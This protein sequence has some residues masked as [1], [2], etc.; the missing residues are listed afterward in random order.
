MQVAGSLNGQDRERIDAVCARCDPACPLRR[1]FGHTIF[2]CYNEQCPAHWDFAR[3][4]EELGIDGD[5][6]RENVTRDL[7]PAPDLPRCA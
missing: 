6:M 5:L 7:W 4:G 2:D 3:L 1:K